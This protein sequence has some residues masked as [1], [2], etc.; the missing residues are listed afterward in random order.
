MEL[1]IAPTHEGI[2]LLGD[3]LAPGDDLKSSLGLDDAV[4]DIEVSPTVRDFLSVIGVAR[5]VAA[6]TGVPFRLPPTDVAEDT[7]PAEGVATVEIARPGT[8]S[9]LPRAHP[10]RCRTHRASPIRVQARLTAAGMRPI[11]AVGRRDELRDARDRA[12]PSRVRPRAAEGTGDRGATG[13]ATASGWS[14][15]TMSSER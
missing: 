1:G 15:S 14:R 10:P 2:L 12:A 8:M 7:E 4:L 13:T 6:A 3:D 9:A 5:E 11:S